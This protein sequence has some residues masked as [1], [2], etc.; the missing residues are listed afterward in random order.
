VRPKGVEKA[1]PPPRL[2]SWAWSMDY[3]CS[4]KV[5]LTLPPRWMSEDSRWR[6]VGTKS[7]VAHTAGSLHVP[8]ALLT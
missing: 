7:K 8:L 5:C 1:S 2:S 6:E 3:Y 4:S